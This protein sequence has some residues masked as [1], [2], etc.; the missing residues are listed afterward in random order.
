MSR[1]QTALIRPMD[2]S[3]QTGTPIY[4]QVAMHILAELAA[5]DA[6]PG[7]RLPSEDALSELFQLTRTTV[8]RGISDLVDKGLLA[9]VHG[10]GTYFR[11]NDV[12]EQPLASSLISFSEALDDLKLKFKT[13]VVHAR[14]INRPPE[15]V[16]FRLNDPGPVFYM[17]RLRSVREVP[18]MLVDS[19]V[20]VAPFPGLLEKAFDR[21]RL[22]DILREDYGVVI[23][24]GSRSFS[25]VGATA[26]IARHLRISVSDPVMFAAQT[27]RDAARCAVEAS[28]IWFPGRH[29]KLVAELDRKHGEKRPP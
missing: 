27:A 19:Y 13:T 26:E 2:A 7:A 21:R 24:T 18:L 22:F 29:F 16:R 14:R 5:H 23:E 4:K 20:P 1:T 12:I 25:A 15:M 9:K 10:G 17:R 11:G 3:H 6:Q 28:D 8:R